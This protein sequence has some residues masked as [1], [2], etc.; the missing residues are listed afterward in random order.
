MLRLR[1]EDPRLVSL[2]GLDIVL[3]L[4]C[5]NVAGTLLIS[6]YDRIVAC[7]GMVKS[8]TLNTCEDL[9]SGRPHEPNEKESTP[10][11]NET[12]C[13][14]RFIQEAA[15]LALQK[16]LV[17]FD[18]SILIKTKQR[19]I[20]TYFLNTHHYL[21]NCRTTFAKIHWFVVILCVFGF[22]EGASVNGLV[23]IS[24]TTLE[25]RF[26]LQL[27]TPYPSIDITPA[28]RRWAG[29][30]WIGFV[31]TC[32][33]YVLLTP[34]I[35]VF[36]RTI[37]GWLLWKQWVSNPVFV[38]VVLVGSAETLI[39]QG[40]AAFSAKL[41]EEKFNYNPADAGLVIGAVT[42]LGGAGGM[43]LG[44]VVIRKF[45]LQVPGMIKLC[46]AMSAVALTFGAAF[47]IN[48]P[49]V[50]TSGINSGSQLLTPCNS[51]C[52]CTTEEY[53]PVCGVDGTVYVSPCHAGCTIVAS[54]DGPNKVRLRV[55]DG[56]STFTHSNA[57]FFSFCPPQ[58]FSNCSC[59]QAAVIAGSGST[60][61][62]GWQAEASSG[63]CASDCLLVWLF[64][65]L[66]FLA[67]LATF[68]T[69]TPVSMA[70]LRCVPE[71][72]KSLG[73]GIQ[74]VSLR[75][76]GTIPGPVLLGVILD[77]TCVLWQETCEGQGSCWVYDRY[78]M[79]WSLFVWWAVIKVF[80]G[81]T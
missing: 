22:V 25:T 30:W 61:S 26:Q 44:G 76:F 53:E 20:L 6:I 37:T 78:T 40:L 41:L 81:L 24:L 48:C 52:R 1:F 10:R 69:V 14:N 56:C 38:L 71:N 33:L 68:T 5:A 27:Y 75:L 47:F 34:L 29:A 67:M 79:S 55:V 72:A 63:E 42:L 15:T 65:P 17:K 39:I 57:S 18:H 43:V 12:S 77:N 36:P 2:M 70:I 59:V 23:S 64:I 60:P 54:E 45:H 11:V 7:H 62:P 13:L 28:D 32:V 74:W 51:A 58:Q 46:I 66:L 31:V 73:L 80:S 50:R 21:Y 8:V 3:S 9:N 35:S 16:D 4:S 19:S 49:E